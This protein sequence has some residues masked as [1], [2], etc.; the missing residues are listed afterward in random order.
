MPT[1]DTFDLSDI[2]ER[3]E[4]E[5][6]ITFGKTVW[7]E[8]TLHTTRQA[9]LY[10]CSDCGFAMFQPGIVG[11]QA[12]Y[13]EVA[14]EEE[15]YYV[16]DRWEF[17]QAG[18]DLKRYGSSRVLD[19][20]CGSG[21][22]L[23]LLRNRAPTVDCVG[24]EFNHQAAQLVRSR[25]HAVCTGS[26]PEAVLAASGE[27]PFDAVCMFQVLEHLRDPIGFLKSVQRLL[28][29]G[30]ILLI[31]VPNA[32]GPIRHFSSALTDIP[33]HHVSRWC[34]STFRI[35]M[36]RLGFSVLKMA[37]EPLPYY[38]WDSYLPVMLEHDLLPAS[39]GRALNRR[40]FTHLFIQLLTRLGL[41]W[42]PGVPGHT[43]YVVLQHDYND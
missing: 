20:G 6:G 2:L 36:P 38:L 29:Q 27:E 1:E 17:L 19:I 9:T 37:S 5:A 11:S 26:F 14:T 30:G 42:L 39:T 28:I 23:D 43:L 18:R 31:S 13:S 33:P 7:Q 16:R 25:G 22:F 15:Q 21:H 32:N 41:R 4:T 24:Y 10:R 34:E 12:F 8:Y 35:G 40:G 3:W